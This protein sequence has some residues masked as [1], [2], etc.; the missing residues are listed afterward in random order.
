MKDFNFKSTD[1]NDFFSLI[2][3]AKKEKK[4]KIGELVSNSFEEYFWEELKKE[5]EPNQK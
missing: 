1:L 4:D 5:V 3:E 2:S